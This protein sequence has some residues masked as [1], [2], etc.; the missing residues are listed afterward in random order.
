M[1]STPQMPTSSM[2]CCREMCRLSYCAVVKMFDSHVDQMCSASNL[3]RHTLDPRIQWMLV[4]RCIFQSTVTKCESYRMHSKILAPTRFF[5]LFTFFTLKFHSLKQ[6]LWNEFVKIDVKIW[7][8]FLWFTT[9]L[10]FLASWNRA[11]YSSHFAL[12]SNRDQGSSFIP[13]PHLIWY[14]QQLNVPYWKLKTVRYR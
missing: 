10:L 3:I 5:T 9:Q 2:L 6:E 11:K 12:V 1:V 7:E 13:G 14:T 8:G 4:I